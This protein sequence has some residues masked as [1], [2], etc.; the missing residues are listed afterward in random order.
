MGD[1]SYWTGEPA[2][3]AWEEGLV[4]LYPNPQMSGHRSAVAKAWRKRNLH[5]TTVQNAGLFLFQSKSDT[6][7]G[8]TGAGDGWQT[9]TLSQFWVPKRTLNHSREFRGIP[10][11]KKL[12]S[13]TNSLTISH[14]G[15]RISQSAI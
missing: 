14:T 8:G 9:A 13:H 12:K 15:T 3:R 1:S 2:V 10:Q 6:I 4:V 5:C 11:S 7:P